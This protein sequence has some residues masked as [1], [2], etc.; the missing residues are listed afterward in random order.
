MSSASE[1]DS[2]RAA[3]VRPPAAEA[4]AIWK[5]FGRKKALQSVSV[6]VRPGEC[7]ALVGRNGAGKSTLVGVLTG[8]LKPDS[9]SV[10][11]Y[12]EPAPSLGDRAAWQERVACVYQRSMVIPSLSVGENIFLGRSRQRLVHWHEL[13]R[14]ARRL[15]LEWGFDLDVDEPVAQLS[16]EQKQIVEIAR[17]LAIGARFLILDEP[18]AS[19]E[20]RAIERLFERVRRVKASGVAILYISHHLEEIYEICDSATVLR[21][22]KAVVTAPLSEL[23]HGRLVAAMVGGELARTI[24]EQTPAAA[25][26]EG[27]PRL[28]VRHLSAQTA[29]GSVDDVSLGVHAAECVGLFGL[30]GSGTA[31]IADAVAGLVK[32]SGGEIE[33]DGRPLR[34]GKVDAALRRGIGYVPEDRHARGFV[35]TLGVA[36]NLTLPILERLCSWGVVSRKRQR[37]AADGIAGRLQIVASS[38]DQLLSE[39]SGGNQQKVVVGRALAARPS[40]LVVVSP[41]VGVDVASKEALLGVIDGAREEGTAV[42]LVSDDLD[43]LR[44]C[45]RVLVVR[46]GKIVKELR[47]PPW[48][49]HELLAAAEGLE[50][51]A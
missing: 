9:G 25:E 30:R 37:E 21:D 32:P 24:R 28:S 43:E 29:L 44:I 3:E 8:L 10:R 20:S 51:A 22:G 48:D 7:H 49:R 1:S 42:L 38:G 31:A 50:T 41:T 27:K 4:E 16:V 5:S 6:S 35:P 12:D 46:R 39:L 33:L 47:D 34:A 36:E 17:A 11:L 15:L 14:Q 26:V 13:R 19:L 23:D 2:G 40:L 45:T 18:T